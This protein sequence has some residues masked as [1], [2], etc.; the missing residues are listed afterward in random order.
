MSI[1]DPGGLYRPPDRAEKGE[2]LTSTTGT[3]GIAGGLGVYA[4]EIIAEAYASRRIL[5]LVRTINTKTGNRFRVLRRKRIAG[6]ASGDERWGTGIDEHAQNSTINPVDPS[7]AN[8]VLS[9]YKLG[10]DVDVTNEALADVSNL[11][12][13]I[14]SD[15]GRGLGYMLALRLVSGSGSQQGAGVRTVLGE[16][17]NSAQTKETAAATGPTYDELQELFRI[18]GDEYLESPTAAVFTS[19]SNLGVIRRV[20]V[21]GTNEPAFREVVDYDGNVYGSLL[22]LPVYTAPGFP[23]IAANAKAV[24][25]VGEWDC[26]ALRFAGEMRSTISYHV[27]Y[28]EDMTRFRFL[29]RYDCDVIDPEGFAALDIGA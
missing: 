23:D 11:R 2:D 5:T 29:Q 10:F 1:K 17:G 25:V 16:A 14:V 15:G 18:P 22:G 8:E 19:R 24:L 9:A 7:Y 21:P 20:T 13:Q 28:G 3:S 6:A 4:T 12:Q 27:R 26:M